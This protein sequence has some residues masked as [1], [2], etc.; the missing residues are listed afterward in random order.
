MAVAVKTS[1]S[2]GKRR[3]TRGEGKVQNL[4]SI[5]PVQVLYVCIYMFPGSQVLVYIRVRVCMQ[6]ESKPETEARV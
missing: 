5:V 3:A 2:L 4:Y 6:R 1:G